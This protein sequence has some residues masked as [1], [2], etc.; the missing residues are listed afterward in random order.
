MSEIAAKVQNPGSLDDGKFRTGL[1]AG[2]PNRLLATLI[3]GIWLTAAAS[4]LV[5]AGAESSYH[6]YAVIVGVGGI[7][8]PLLALLTLQYGKGSM[9]KELVS[10]KDEKITGQKLWALL[11]VAW[12]GFGAGFGTF[13]SP[14]EATTN[15][16]FA[17]W[18]GFLFSLLGLADVMES[19]G[20]KMKGA[21][22]GNPARGLFFA[23]VVL[24][25][26]LIPYVDNENAPWY[27]ESV[28]GIVSASLTIVVCLVLIL[29]DNLDHT[30]AQVVA[31]GLG[32]LWIAT[33]GVLTFRCAS[34]GDDSGAAAA[35]E[36]PPSLPAT[37]TMH[38]L[39]NTVPHRTKSSP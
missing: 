30:I 12:W 1:A 5:D 6:T 21:K 9:D 16:Y 32:V 2:F 38:Q 25:I 33:A 35:R 27:G 10:V 20:S 24:L 18:A 31:A 26:A 23:A 17:L 19:V 8:F 37:H 29:A 4:L 3:C 7:I 13:R 39:M 34:F 14:F 15:G 11:L 36:R 28:F 22:V